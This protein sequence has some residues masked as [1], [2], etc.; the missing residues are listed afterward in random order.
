MILRESFRLSHVLLIAVALLTV[1]CGN[2]T[3]TNDTDTDSLNKEAATD[4]LA[5]QADSVETAPADL[6]TVDAVKA[7]IKKMY[8]RLN[9]MAKAGNINLHQMDEEFCTG[10]Y[11]QLTH[12][13]A[14]HDANAKGDMRFYGDEEGYRWM[15]DQSA[16]FTIEKIHA[17]LLTGNM[18]RAQVS[19]K[20][21]SPE[22]EKGFMVLD[23]WM[24]GG[25][26][27]VNNFIEPEVF[28]N[29]GYISM[30]E[31]YARDNHIAIE[32]NEPTEGA[33]M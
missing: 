31:K 27:R 30:M 4:S 16:P 28:G 33:P 24:E 6:W 29:E 8:D 15:T 13:I 11:L 3:K 12:A 19:L 2:K 14:A 20:T 10:Y 25:R 7:D 5:A 26:W 1:S 23:L 18:A 17:E 21:N 32:E 9:Q 22:D